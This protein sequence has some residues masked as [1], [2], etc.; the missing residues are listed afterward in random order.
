MLRS[1]TRLG[2]SS[3]TVTYKAEYVKDVSVSIIFIGTANVILFKVVII[4]VASVVFSVL[5]VANVILFIEIIYSEANIAMLVLIME[6]GQPNV[7]SFSVMIMCY[8]ATH[9]CHS[10]NKLSCGGSDVV[11]WNMWWVWQQEQYSADKVFAV[12][13]YIKYHLHSTIN[14]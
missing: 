3:I 10:C 4:W 8:R 14:K 13:V 1:H 9:L 12:C 11:L 5:W 7:I 6:S 2:G